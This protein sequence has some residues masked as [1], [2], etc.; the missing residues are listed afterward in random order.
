M[1]RG[2]RKGSP[3][4]RVKKADSSKKVEDT[5]SM[6]VQKFYGTDR[7]T[8]GKRQDCDTPE[9]SSKSAAKRDGSET[10]DKSP[11]RPGTSSMKGKCPSRHVDLSDTRKGRKE[12]SRYVER[13]M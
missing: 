5:D 7:D 4:K 11:P 3:A 9:K 12:A 2:K 8:G 10:R 13:Q 1:A 6:D